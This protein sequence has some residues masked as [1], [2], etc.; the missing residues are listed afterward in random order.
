E[1]GG[2]FT[3]DVGMNFTYF[4]QLVSRNWS[5][6]MTDIKNPYK[7]KTQQSDN[8]YTFG[9]KCLG[10][11][12]NSQDIYNSARRISSNNIVS[13]DLKYADING[14][15]KIDGEDQERIGSSTMPAI[16]YGIYGNFGY[17]GV[18]LN[19]LFQGASDRSYYVGAEYNGN[20]M[21]N[22]LTYT[23]QLDYW[24]PTNRDAKYPRPQG[25][26]LSN[27]GLNYT[28][29]DFWLINAG[30]VRLKTLQVGYDFK[31]TLL[32]NT[33]WL[34]KLQISL[35]GQNLF[36]ISE[37]QKYGYDPESLGTTLYPAVR[38]FSL[39]VSLGF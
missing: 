17:K 3:Y 23:R 31:H 10:Y 36:T 19:I 27:N 1:T 6:N 22:P 15:G 26:A 29:S 8:Y 11:Y 21:Q 38:T 9:Y 18:F 24:T 30:Y 20:N 5:E 33:T 14:D 7:R 37:A 25:A 35:S 32:R 39:N 2:G 13:G 34:S 12:N 4:D 28:T 16:N